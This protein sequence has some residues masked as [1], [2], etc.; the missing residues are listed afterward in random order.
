M[1][2][3]QTCALPIYGTGEVAIIQQNGDPLC[4]L[5]YTNNFALLGLH[6]AA[7][8]TGDPFYREA[9]DKLARFLCRVQ[10]RSEDHPQLDGAWYRAFDF[11]RWEYWASN[12][13]W[14]WG[15]WC[16]ESGW[17]APWIAGTFALRRMQTS[18]WDLT[19]DI[20]IAESV[21]RYRAEMLPDSVLAPAD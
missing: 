4:D 11:Q 10:I 7:A 1:P 21:K 8:A 6:E 3:V 13:D 17:A 12:A 2:G 20:R 19:A 9:E 14:E 5:L 16:A 15:A 18:L